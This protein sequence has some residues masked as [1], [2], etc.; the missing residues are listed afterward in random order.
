LDNI[1]IYILSD[2]NNLN[3]ILKEELAFRELETEFGLST[4]LNYRRRINNINHKKS[5]ENNSNKVLI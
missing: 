5:K 1:D 4:N 3:I 2:S